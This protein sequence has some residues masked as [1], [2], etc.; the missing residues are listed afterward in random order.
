MPF[1]QCLFFSLDMVW[2]LGL[3]YTVEPRSKLGHLGKVPRTWRLLVFV[4]LA[5]VARGT[6]LS[7]L[8]NPIKNISTLLYS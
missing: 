6:E 4:S 3:V 1:A 5:S 7:E 8:R 2:D